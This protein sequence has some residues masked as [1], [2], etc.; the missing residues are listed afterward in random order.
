MWRQYSGTL[1]FLAVGLIA[2]A[3]YVAFA[4]RQARRRFEVMRKT[5]RENHEETYI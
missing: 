2:V 5:A 3:V 1:L 4:R